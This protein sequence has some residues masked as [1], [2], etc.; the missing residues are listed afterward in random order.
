VEDSPLFDAAAANDVALLRALLDEGVDPD[1]RTRQGFTALHL[2]A[3]EYAVAA[4]RLLLQFGADVDARNDWGNSALWVASFNS[5]GRGDLITLLLDHG[6]DP[7]AANDAG[8]TPRELVN[9]IA[10]HDVARFFDG[11]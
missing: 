7:D 4:A 1:T 9:L 8:R 3:Q 2:A 6:A 5:R 10:N 11:R